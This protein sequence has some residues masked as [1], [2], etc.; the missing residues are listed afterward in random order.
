MTALT[1]VNATLPAHLIA[2]AEKAQDYAANASAENTKRAY[3]A[4]WADFIAWCAEKDCP[5]LPAP[6]AVVGLYLA[7]RA[8]TLKPSTLRLRLVAIRTMHK[9]HGHHLDT[10]A[11]QIRR[12]LQGIVRTHGTATRKVEAATIEVIRDVVRALAKIDGPKAL[13]DRALLLIGFAAALRRSEISAIDLAHIRFGADGVVLTLPRRKTD[14]EGEGTEIGIPFGKDGQYCPVKTLQAWLDHAGIT[15]GAVF[16]SIGKGGRILPSRLGDKDVARAIKNAVA[17]AGYD[18]D[19]FGGHSL[20]SGFATT[21]GR[22]GVPERI[23][24]LTT[25]HKSL[26]VLRGY[27]RRGALFAEN[28]AAMIGL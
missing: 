26:P 3:E 6:E 4:G 20:R 23:I 13:R 5:A 9:N 18:A 28:A 2:T 14:Q 25:G 19:Q 8:E 17:V 10:A 11:P 21:A 16:P 27:I 12:V 22:V 24:M 1:T 15:D 7:D